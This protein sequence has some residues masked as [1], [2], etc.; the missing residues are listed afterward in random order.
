[1]SGEPIE[2]TN[3]SQ[4]ELEIG[5]HRDELYIWEGKYEAAVVVLRERLAVDLQNDNVDSTQELRVLLC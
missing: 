4:V 1:M 3:G 2:L 5:L